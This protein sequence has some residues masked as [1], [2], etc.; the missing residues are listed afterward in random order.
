VDECKP[1][2]PGKKGI[3]LSRE[4]WS[5]LR[6]TV[7]AVT[8]A[9]EAAADEE[10]VLCE[11][12]GDRKVTVQKFKVRRRSLTLS[13]PMLTAPGSERLKL[14]HDAPHRFQCCFNFAFK[15]NLRRYIK[16]KM[17]VSIREFYTK[18]GN[19]S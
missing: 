3:S 9:V 5:A 10:K 7:P 19:T 18:V 11:M 2:L 16:G 8:A 13:N 17:L 4:Q 1:L 15:F 12:S 14:K 6:D